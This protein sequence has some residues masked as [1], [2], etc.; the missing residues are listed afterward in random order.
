[1]FFD[2]DAPDLVTF[3]KLPEWIRKK[4]TANLNFNGS[5]LQNLLKMAPKENKEVEE[6]DEDERPF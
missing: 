3:N 5:V 4:I 2:L 1:V 6:K